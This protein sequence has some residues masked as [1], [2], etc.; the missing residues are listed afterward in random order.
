LW[1]SATPDV[2]RHVEPRG[3]PVRGR[4]QFERK[5]EEAHVSEVFLKQ[6]K[7][8]SYRFCIDNPINHFDSMSRSWWALGKIDRPEELINE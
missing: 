8:N 6:V 4:D 1:T 3:R 2:S 7:E 5:F